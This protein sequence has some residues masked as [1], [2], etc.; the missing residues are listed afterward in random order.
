MLTLNGMN[1]YRDR[2][3]NAL[4]ERRLDLKQSTLCIMY[5]VYDTRYSYF[6]SSLVGS[7]LIG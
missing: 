5:S 1:Y 7:K 3:L 6:T 2:K 4:L